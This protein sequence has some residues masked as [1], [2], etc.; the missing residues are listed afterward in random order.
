MRS[1]TSIYLC[2]LFIIPLCISEKKLFINNIAT[3]KGFNNG[4]L[5]WSEI[6]YSRD[7]VKNMYTFTIELTIHKEVSKNFGMEFNLWKCDSEGNLDSCEYFLKEKKDFH[8]CDYL[9]DEDQFWSVF[10]MRFVPPLVCPIKPGVYKAINVP[11]DCEY[12]LILPIDKPIV[13]SRLFGYDN[14]QT[15]SCVDIELS[16]GSEKRG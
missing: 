12:C 11:F 13:R 16:F 9:L 5:D 6:S 1:I 14:N 8:I 15:I 4:S 3:C 7:P 2:C 10:V